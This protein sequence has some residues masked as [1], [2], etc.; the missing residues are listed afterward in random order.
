M[1]LTGHR[2][3]GIG[4]FVSC[5]ASLLTLLVAGWIGL[6]FFDEWITV[7]GVFFLAL[8]PPDLV[9]ACR[10]W[11]DSTVEL[12]GA[13]AFYLT[14]RIYAGGGERWPS[15]ALAV[16]CACGILVKETFLLIFVPCMVVVL[17]KAIKVECDLTKGL[18]TLAAGIL[19]SAIV[20]AILVRCTGG[21]GTAIGIV[22]TTAKQHAI[23]PYT[24]QTSTGPGYLLAVA[25]DST[26]PVLIRLAGCGVL[27]VFIAPLMPFLHRLKPLCRNAAAV[28]LFT[29]LT[30]GFVG[31]FAV[32]P[33]WLNLRFISAAYPPICLLAGLALRQCLLFMQNTL[34]RPYLFRGLAV[35]GVITIAVLLLMDVQR[36]HTKYI[37]GGAT[38][39][40]MGLILGP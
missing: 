13:L 27:L 4:S 7:F 15:A 2:G 33:H 40:S 6:S 34:R 31:V 16:V 8:F 12:I 25:L 24:L 11:Q 29:T 21:L 37:L 36:A 28:R 22:L 9:L 3:E 1:I 14:L 19:T 30:L 39:L 23:Y 17:W 35:G 10:C 5:S 20:L 26:A 18:V 38:D 32:V